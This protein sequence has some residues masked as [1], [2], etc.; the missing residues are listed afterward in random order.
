MNIEKLKEFASTIKHCGDYGELWVN[1]ELKEVWWVAGDADFDEDQVAA[2]ICTGYDAI[3]EGFK[4]DG[5]D[6]VIIEAESGPWDEVGE[7]YVLLGKFGIDNW[8][9]VKDFYQ[10]HY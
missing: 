1:P 5:V 2:G 6:A 10:E 3:K 8:D 7:G 4:I 9:E